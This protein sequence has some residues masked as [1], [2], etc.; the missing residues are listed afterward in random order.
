MLYNALFLHINLE[1]W[2]ALPYA[3]A[4]SLE[5]TCY[6]ERTMEAR[7]L[8]GRASYGP[9]TLKVLFQAF[10]EAWQTFAPSCGESPLSI[11]AGRLKLANAILSVAREG[12]TDARALRDG[13]LKLLGGR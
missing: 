8:I 9:E 10:D 6:G 1:P 5:S 12:S 13:A 7:R 4:M 11:H 3:A 2:A